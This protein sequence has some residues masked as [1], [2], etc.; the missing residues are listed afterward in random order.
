MEAAII[1]LSIAL[2]IAFVFIAYQRYAINDEKDFSIKKDEEIEKLRDDLN[3]TIKAV[4]A[5]KRLANANAR[6]STELKCKLE[7]SK[8][9]YEELNAKYDELKSKYRSAS[10]KAG[11][12]EKKL[13]DVL[14]KL[15]A[16]IKKHEKK[17]NNSVEK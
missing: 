1:L 6:V 9:D 3:Y 12:Y 17:Q 2:V 16:K 10:T 4:E 15:E 11:L 13:K 5:N 7:D 14:D 8:K